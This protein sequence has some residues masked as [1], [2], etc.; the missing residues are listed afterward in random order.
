MATRRNTG[1]SAKSAKSGF[2]AA[3]IKRVRRHVFHRLIV[4]RDFQS[5]FDDIVSEILLLFASRGRGQ[6]VE[7]A[8]VETIRK[9]FGR[10]KGYGSK[11]GIDPKTERK[12]IELKPEFM[13]P[14]IPSLDSFIF[15]DQLADKL[16]GRERI[17]FLLRFKE[18]WPNKEIAYLF[19]VTEGRACHYLTETLMRVKELLDED[20]R[21]HTID[22]RMFEKEF[23]E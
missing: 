16:E 15:I 8:Y 12:E 18:G 17:V 5:H 10:T 23:V 22:F 1:S 2:D 14:V 3:F 7:Q 13:E 9:L 19:G 20:E 11:R 6:T 4:H 21:F